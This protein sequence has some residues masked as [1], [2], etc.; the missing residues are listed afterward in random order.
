M[1]R[2]V[3]VCICACVRARVCVVSCSRSSSGGSGGGVRV[4]A[5]AEN[6]ASEGSGGG[7]VCSVLAL[8]AALDGKPNQFTCAFIHMRLK[9]SHVPLGVVTSCFQCP[10]LTWPRRTAGALPGATLIELG[11]KTGV[12]LHSFPSW[13]CQ[14]TRFKRETRNTRTQ[15]KC[16]CDQPGEQTEGGSQHTH[17]ATQCA[18]TYTCTYTHTCTHMRA[19]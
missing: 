12:F 17:M 7:K 11:G 19:C 2:C 3:C 4:H 9:D 1:F 16:I 18:R 5:V 15:R 6:R 8:S 10:A 14:P 13:T